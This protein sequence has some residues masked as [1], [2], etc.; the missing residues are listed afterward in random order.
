MATDSDEK[1]NMLRIAANLRT[2]AADIRKNAQSAPQPNAE[3][4][5]RIADMTDKQAADIET[6]AR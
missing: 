1:K 6:A 4:L 2:A 5:Q 3:A